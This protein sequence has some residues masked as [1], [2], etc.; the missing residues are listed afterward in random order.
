[1]SESRGLSRILPGPLG[2]D[3]AHPHPELINVIPEMVHLE[4]ES[5]LRPRGPEGMASPSP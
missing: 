3:N 5:G 1:M 4:E 2:G